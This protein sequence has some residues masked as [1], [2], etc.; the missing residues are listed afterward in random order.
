MSEQ[1]ETPGKFR[2]GDEQEGTTVPGPEPTPDVETPAPEP[3]AEPGEAEHEAGAT[4]RPERVEE[5]K[6]MGA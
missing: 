3:D 1:G 5:R 2:R 4:D 6:G